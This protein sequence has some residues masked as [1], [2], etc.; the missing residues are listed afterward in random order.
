MDFFQAANSTEEILIDDSGYRFDGSENEL[1]ILK[2]TSFDKTSPDSE[3][4]RGRTMGN[5]AVSS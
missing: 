4:S 1:A 5:M 2:G 3:S